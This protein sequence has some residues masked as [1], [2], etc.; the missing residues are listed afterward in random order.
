MP[1]SARPILQTRGSEMIAEEIIPTEKPC[2]L[3]ESQ[4][5]TLE[6][7][8]KCIVKA[9]I[10]FKKAKLQPEIKPDPNEINL[11]QIFVEQIAFQLIAFTDIAVNSGYSDLFF[12]TKGISDFYFFH[13]EQGKV[14]LPLFVVESKRLPAPDNKKLREKEYVIGDKKNGGIERYKKEIH[15]KNFDEC[16]MVGFIEKYTPSY[17]LNLINSWIHELA[18]TDL[19]WSD[20]ELLAIKEN[21]DDYSY[22][23]SIA[24]RMKSDK[25]VALHHWWIICEHKSQYMNFSRQ[26]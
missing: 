26:S 6:N 2:D 14:N 4:G 23:F 9:I 10:P 13:R 3:S 1:I 25:N 8:M 11:T 22:L 12:G 17:W 19:G 5:K 21:T 15:G 20:N 16:G 18:K 7:I 24:N